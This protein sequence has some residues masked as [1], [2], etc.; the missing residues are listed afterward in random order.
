MLDDDWFTD[1]DS[2]LSLVS[3]RFST[4]VMI[5]LEFVFGRV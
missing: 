2:N 4:H 5:K 1:K 3:E